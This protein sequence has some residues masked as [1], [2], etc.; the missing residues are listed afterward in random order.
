MF[1]KLGKILSQPDFDKAAELCKGLDGR[2]IRKLVPAACAF[3]KETALDPS[4]MTVADLVRAAK[5]ARKELKLEKE[6]S[7]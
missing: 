4:R 7:Q 2:R 3:S 1:P 6:R 5:D